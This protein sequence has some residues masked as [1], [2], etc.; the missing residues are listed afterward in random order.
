MSAFVCAPDHFKALAVFAAS[1]SGGYGTSHFHVDPRYLRGL[2]QD[3]ERGSEHLTGRELASLYADVLY[4]ENLRSVQARYPQDSWETLP[5]PCEKPRRMGVT[6]SEL[7][8][9]KYRLD[10]VVVLKLCDGLEYQ[11]CETDDYRQTVAFDLLDRIRSA[12]IRAL[13][14]YEQAPW[15]YHAP[16]DARTQRAG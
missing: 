6:A 3:A 4:Q 1:R 11:S 7:H 10:P 14:G 2:P 12:A 5:G 15:E 9:A 13:P 16:Q 8:A